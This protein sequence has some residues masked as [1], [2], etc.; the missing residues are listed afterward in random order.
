ML[1]GPEKSYHNPVV[2]RP[3]YRSCGYG[4]RQNSPSIPLAEAGSCSLRTQGADSSVLR[5]L[6]VTPHSCRNRVALFSFKGGKEAS[7]F[8]KS[9]LPFGRD[10]AADYSTVVL[11]RNSPKPEGALLNPRGCETLCLLKPWR[12][13]TK[14][15]PKAQMS[16]SSLVPS[17]PSCLATLPCDMRALCHLRHPCA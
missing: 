14:D 10:C 5:G 9:T 2:P 15:I 4:L 17:A 8:S 3:P 7:S 11:T 13:S 16:T 6:R 12:P 1:S